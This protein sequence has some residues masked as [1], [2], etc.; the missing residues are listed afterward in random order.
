MNDITFNQLETQ[1]S[2]QFYRIDSLLFISM[3]SQAYYTVASGN[4]HLEF[5][6]N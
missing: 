6:L 1:N 4:D 5:I 2:L 3:F